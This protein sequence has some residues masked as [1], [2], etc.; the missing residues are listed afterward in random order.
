M[1]SDCLLIFVESFN[2]IQVL[3][4]MNCFWRNLKSCVFY[5]NNWDLKVAIVVFQGSFSLNSRWLCIRMIKRVLAMESQKSRDNFAFD[6][7]V[8]CKSLPRINFI[9]IFGSRIQYQCLKFVMCRIIEVFRAWT[10]FSLHQKSVDPARFLADLEPDL[11]FT[12]E[13]NGS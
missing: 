9:G 2:R 13:K 12:F 10:G 11:D 5:N 7:L 1:S 8:D 3:R 4:E 6:C